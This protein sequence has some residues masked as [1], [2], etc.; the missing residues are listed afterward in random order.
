MRTYPRKQG[1]P[2]SEELSPAQQIDKLRE[3]LAHLEVSARE[4]RALI[5][6]LEAK[7]RDAT[8]KKLSV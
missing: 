5:A 4:V 7:Q 1:V 6:D 2:E 8:E 3:M